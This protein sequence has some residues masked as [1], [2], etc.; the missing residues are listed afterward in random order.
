MTETN[1]YGPQN[2]GDDYLRKPTSS[3]RAVPPME[4]RVTDEEGNSLPPGG[5]GE[6]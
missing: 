6:I 3:G 5:V 1:A 4:L 2:A